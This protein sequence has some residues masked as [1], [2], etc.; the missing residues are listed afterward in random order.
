MTQFVHGDLS[1]RQQIHDTS[2]A[3]SALLIA[4]SLGQS[5]YEMWRDSYS[6]MLNFS[7][8]E[9]KRALAERVLLSTGLTVGSRWM[10]ASLAGTTIAPFWLSVAGLSLATSTGLVFYNWLKTP[11]EVEFD[12]P[13]EFLKTFFYTAS[14][15]MVGM[16]LS[17]LFLPMLAPA[18]SQIARSVFDLAVDVGLEPLQALVATGVVHPILRYQG[19]EQSHNDF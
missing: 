9:G 11:D 10:V 12:L 8:W 1:L 15:T 7:T 13:T 17:R 16:G 5:E 6:T 19:I 2:L 14:G 18:A 4:N 3:S